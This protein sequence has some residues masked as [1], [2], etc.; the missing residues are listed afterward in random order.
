MLKRKTLGSLVLKTLKGSASAQ[1]GMTLVEIMVVIAILGMMGTLITVYFVKQQEIA[2]VDGTKIQ[3]HNIKQA[4]DT[5]KIKYGSYPSTEEGLEALIS[6]EIMP[7]LP[8]DM[9]E[10]EFQY[11]RH[12]S[13]SY[14]LKSFGADGQAGG[15]GVDGD[16]IEEQ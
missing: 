8:R 11:I 4:L 14:S 5:Y 7:E 9:W 3:M 6:K 12:N 16:L 10:R 13:R 1:R 2:K 15:E